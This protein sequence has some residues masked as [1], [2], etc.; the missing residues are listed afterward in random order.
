MHNMAY[1]LKARTV[2]SH[3][4]AISRQCPANNRGMVFPAWSV[5]MAEYV[6][7]E[8]AMPLLY[9]NC[10]AT[11]EPRFLCS[12]CQDIISRAVSRPVNTCL[13]ENKNLGHESQR[14]WS[15]EWLCWRWYL[16]DCCG[17]VIVSCCCSKLVAEAGDSSGNPEEGECPPLQAVIRRLV[18]IQKA[19]KT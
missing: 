2:E 4:P 8:Y 12:P 6:I 3:Q 16:E 13:G 15:Q 10:T 18:K 5:L 19:E 11:E 17:T 1:S 14:E 9:N 7:M